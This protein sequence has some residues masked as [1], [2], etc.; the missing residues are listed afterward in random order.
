MLPYCHHSQAYE[1]LLQTARIEL[2]YCVLA[3]VSALRL[4]FP[5]GL[6]MVSL[7]VSEALSDDSLDCPFGAL[8]VV[9]T[10]PNAVAVPEIKFGQISVQMFLFAML[11]DAYHSAF[12]NRVIA[13]NRVGVDNPAHVFIDR[14]GDGLMHPI[15]VTEFVVGGQFVAHHEGFLRDVG[16]NDRQE[17]PARRT[18]DMEATGA[19]ES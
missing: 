2:S 5:Y 12:E 13:L 9:Y 17:L 11:I 3:L 4:L 14:M 18:L 15:L 16:A 1:R 19:S 10:K 8:H 7:P 6:S